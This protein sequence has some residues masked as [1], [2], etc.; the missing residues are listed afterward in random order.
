MI[1]LSVNHDKTKQSIDSIERYAY[2]I[3]KEIIHKN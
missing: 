3:N 2:E 1:A